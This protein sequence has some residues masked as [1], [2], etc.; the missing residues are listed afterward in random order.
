MAYIDFA[1]T[2]AP[3]ASV[4]P[5]PQHDITPN[6]A[7]RLSPLEWSVVAIARR[8]RLASL[9]EPGRISIAMGNLFGKGANPRLAD[10]RLEAL[11]RMAVLSWHHG[12]QVPVSA[13]R[14]FLAA[15]FTTDHYEAMLASIS[16][17]K[18]ATPAR[19]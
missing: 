2:P 3:A 15:G 7:G 19:G 8:D 16:A 4:A 17:A 1:E 14:A 9:R 6:E 18:L 12:F 10:P 13:V 5:A 11:R